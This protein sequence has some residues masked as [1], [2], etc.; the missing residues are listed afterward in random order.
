ML[1]HRLGAADVRRHDQHRVAEVDGAAL[2]VGQAAVVEHLQQDVEDLGVRLLDLVEQDDAVRAAAHRLRQLAALVVADVAGRRADEAR[3]RV[4][5]LVLAHVD[6]HHRVLVVEHELGE[7]ARELR[8]ADAGRAEEDERP[9][10]PVRD[11]AGRC[12]RGGARSRPRRPPR[13]G[14]RRAGAGAPPCGSASRSPPRAAG[15]PGCRSSGRRWW[16]CRP[17]RPLP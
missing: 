4:P 11:P 14:R 17:R 15:R 1:A 9:D 8:L 13:P 5:L 3:H 12:A 6:A 2:A 7:R 10:R 16:R